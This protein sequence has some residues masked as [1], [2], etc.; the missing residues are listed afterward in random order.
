MFYGSASKRMIV[1]AIALMTFFWSAACVGAAK[2]DQWLIYWY[3][4]GTDIESARIAFRTGTDLLSDDPNA[5]ILAD[6]VKRPGDATRCINEVE[7]AALSPNVKIFMQAGGTYVWGHKKFRDNNAKFD[8][9]STVGAGNYLAERGMYFDEWRMLG[10]KWAPKPVKNGKLS[11]Y[12][13]DKDHR[14][15][16]P[17]EQLPISGKPNTITD[18]GSQAGLIDF[19]KAGQRLERELYPDGNVRRLFIFV[20]HGIMGYYGL[21][22]VCKDAYT[23][24]H[25]SLKDIQSAF[26]D[27]KDGWTNSEDK[28]FEVVAFDACVMSTYETAFALKDTANYMVASQEET[29]GKVMFGYTGLLNELSNEPTMSGANLGRVI[30]KTYWTDSKNTDKE[31]GISANTMLTLSVV[32]LSENKMD[33]LKNA[34]ENFGREARAFAQQHSDELI[35]TVTKFSNAANR[36]EKYPSVAAAMTFG[37]YSAPELVDLR[38]L[39]KNLGQNIPELKQVGKELVDAIDG[40]VIYQKRGDSLKSGGGLSIYYPFDLLDSGVNIGKYKEFI[41][42][43]QLTPKTQGELYEFLYNGLIKN[44]LSNGQLVLT[45]DP[46]TKRPGIGIPEHSPLSMRELAE[47]A[48]EVDENK[49]TAW[50]ELDEDQCKKIEGVRC[51]L[52]YV[53]S[54]EDKLYAKILGNDVGIKSDWQEGIFESTFDGKW[55]TIAGQPIFAQVV[56]DSTR[57]NKKGKKVGGSELS[58]VPILLNGEVRLLFVTCEYPKQ[59][60][61]V[62]GASPLADNNGMPAGEIYGLKQGD[63]VTPIYVNSHLSE[64]D[65][66]K[67]EERAQKIYG[68]TLDDLSDEE[69]IDVAQGMYNVSFGA[70]ITLD[71]D[72]LKIEMSALPDGNYVYVFE[73]INPIG[74]KNNVRT[75]EAAI[76]K[77]RDGNIIEVKHS[78]DIEELKDFR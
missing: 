47:I 5:L 24:N 37:G 2:P 38:G 56:S 43:A 10:K 8:T 68:R 16:R 42:T 3:V 11:R 50:I 69:K 20:D 45:I 66:D 21:D 71:S 64:D 73:F 41:E 44:G 6:P 32:D 17:R 75:E 19:L 22:G 36:A 40:A 61:T 57:K 14:N 62:V 4:C 48:V 65:I 18:M 78:D 70:P 39:V 7:K 63:V 29:H 25:L 34:Y 60:F 35:Q 31:F 76:F 15:W 27:V 53:N 9:K 67:V 54:V 28:P 12:I 59:K 33:A 72:K 77:I 23:K 51:N 55:V 46:K 52:I 30:C 13:Y 26:S 74:G 58:A 49:K 1:V